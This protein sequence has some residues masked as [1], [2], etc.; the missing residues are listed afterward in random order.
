MKICLLKVYLGLPLGEA[1]YRGNQGI[2]TNLSLGPFHR[3]LG[4]WNGPSEWV[5]I[6]KGR[7]DISALVD[8][9][10]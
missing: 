1:P 4:G 10:P 9:R 3:E 2:T 5:C 7:A 8:F 6:E